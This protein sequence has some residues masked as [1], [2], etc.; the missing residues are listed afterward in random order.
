MTYVLTDRYVRRALASA[1]RTDADIAEA[2]SAY[3]YPRSR[4]RDPGFATLLRIIVGQQVSTKAAASIF[5]RLMDALGG[6]DPARLLRLRRTT[7]RKVGLSRAKTEYVRALATAIAREGLELSEF[8]ALADDEVIERLTAI[9][10]IGLWSAQIYL[11]FC[12]GRPDVWP[13]GDLGVLNGL[14]RIKGVDARPTPA[15]SEAMVACFAPKRSAIA[16]LAWHVVNAP[17]G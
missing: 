15:Q 17:P 14:Q 5:A 6:E 7:L 16:L 8:G 9:R 2:L 4:R 13:R 12:L 11:M 3:G 10:G 1:A